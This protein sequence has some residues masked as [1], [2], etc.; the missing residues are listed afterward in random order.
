MVNEPSLL[1]VFFGTPAFAV[2]TL[3]ALLASR[4]VVVGVVTQPDRPRG[5]GQKTSAS[6]VK[7]VAVAAAVPVVQPQSVKTAEF[8]SEFSAF[9]A[10]IGVVAAYGQILTATLLAETSIGMIKVHDSLLAH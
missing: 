8:S 6:P 9:G 1:V 7:D 4:H 3:K 2:P 5:R 10:D